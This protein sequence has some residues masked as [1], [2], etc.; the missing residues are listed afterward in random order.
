MLLEINYYK[1]FKNSKKHK[2]EIIYVNNNEN[3]MKNNH[4]GFVNFLM[5]KVDQYKSDLKALTHRKNKNKENSKFYIE[6]IDENTDIIT[7]GGKITDATNGK[8]IIRFDEDD[9]KLLVDERIYY[10]SI[11]WEVPSEDFVKVIS[12]NC[13]EYLEFKVCAI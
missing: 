4:D 12:S 11:W 7:D 6:T 8:V 2:L 1:N 3:N 5:E 10:L 13:G 9:F